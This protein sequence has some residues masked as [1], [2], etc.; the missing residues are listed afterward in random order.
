MNISNSTCN[1]YSGRDQSLANCTNN[2]W[3][4]ASYATKAS[5]CTN[6][7]CYDV[8]CFPLTVVTISQQVLLF[9]D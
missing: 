5:E 7:G 8:L 1:L 3:S 2:N 9:N 4:L 6:L